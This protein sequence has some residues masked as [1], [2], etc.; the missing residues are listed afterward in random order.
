MKIYLYKIDGELIGEYQNSLKVIGDKKTLAKLDYI[1][2]DQTYALIDVNYNENLL[3]SNAKFE[4]YDVE[5]C[6]LNKENKECKRIYKSV[7]KNGVVSKKESDFKLLNAP[8]DD[9]LENNNLNLNNLLI[10]S[11]YDF[12]DDDVYIVIKD[13]IEGF[14]LV[15]DNGYK[16]PLQVSEKG[17]K[18]SFSLLEEYYVNFS[19]FGYFE[20]K[21]DGSLAVKEIYFPFYSEYKEYECLL[22]IKGKL[23]IEIEF[24]VSTSDKL[25]GECENSK[26]CIEESSYD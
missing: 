15:Y 8:F 7:Y 25:F 21:K 4:F 2:N 23:N 10:Y 14:D 18:Y 20:S 13:E 19:D 26:Y 17:L 16:L 11:D 5:K 6:Y 1:Y 9:F 22:V 24:K 12:S 3:V